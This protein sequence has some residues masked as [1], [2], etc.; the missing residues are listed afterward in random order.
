MADH[1]VTLAS[2][3]DTLE[4]VQAA[5]TPPKP[6]E[7]PPAETPPVD[8]AKAAPAAADGAAAP[9]TPGAK[10]DEAKGGEEEGTPQERA[11]KTRNRLQDRIDEL[12]E[13]R[14]TAEGRLAAREEE[15]ARL[16]TQLDAL[17][18]GKPAGAAP[19]EPAQAPKPTPDKFETYEAYIDALFEWNN[20][21]AEA[22]VQE[23]ITKAIED[24]RKAR[25]V[26]ATQT[27]YQGRVADARTR[28]ADF[29]TVTDQD[30]PVSPGMLAVITQSDVGPDISYYLGK[31]PEECERLAALPNDVAYGEM[32]E[33]AG[34]IRAERKAAGG[35]TKP[36]AP[37]GAAPAARATVTRAP[38]P[39]VPPRGSTT[40]STANPDEMP[41]QDY[42]KWRQSQGAR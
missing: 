38:A 19:T 13:A 27:A 1:L 11:A 40:G 2:T 35:D 12:T 32:R 33:L 41:Y 25:Q 31:H 16:N 21:Q 29:D 10:P 14:Y 4:Q 34:Q 3:T 6:G 24:D 30:L 20:A 15:I 37:A 39:V 22:R 26:E 23:R 36:A 28:Y 18:T 42:K 9:E 7:T 5:L 17:K 8:Q